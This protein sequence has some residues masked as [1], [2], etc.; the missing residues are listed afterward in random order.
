MIPKIIHYCWFGNNPLPDH[1]RKCIESWEKNC[2]DY[3]IICW[4]ESNYDIHKCKYMTDAYNKNKLGFVPDYARLD[5]IYTYGGIYLDTDV[6]V[7][8]SFDDLLSN[9]GFAGFESEQYVN[10]GQG[11]GAEK[12]NEIIKEL[13]DSYNKMSFINE[14]GE[15]N[16]TASPILNS[17]KLCELGFIMNGVEQCVSG[18]KIYPK[19]FFCPLD[20]STGILLKS[21]NTYSIHTFNGSWLSPETKKAKKVSQFCNRHFGPL[22]DPIFKVYKYVLHPSNLIKKLKGKNDGK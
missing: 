22:A 9:E 13:R 3:E 5:I 10:L 4:N 21:S 8:K 1:D 19:D 14:N 11:F 6:I 20:Y 2:P 17:K 16:L 15:I 7:E 12:G 18:F